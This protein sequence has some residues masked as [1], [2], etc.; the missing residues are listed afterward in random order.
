MWNWLL[1]QDLRALDLVILGALAFNHYRLRFI[2]KWILGQGG[3]PRGTKKE[4]SKGQK[5]G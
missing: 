1:N 5:M 3:N 4:E 2:T